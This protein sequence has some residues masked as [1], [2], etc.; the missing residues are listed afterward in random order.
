MWAWRMEVGMDGCSPG[1]GV[2]CECVCV[3]RVWYGVV[4][5]G[6]HNRIV[7]GFFSHIIPST[8]PYQYYT[9]ILWTTHSNVFFGR[10]SQAFPLLCPCFVLP[11]NR[12]ISMHTQCTKKWPRWQTPNNCK[13]VWCVAVQI[14][15]EQHSQPLSSNHMFRGPMLCGYTY[16]Y[17]NNSLSSDI[18]LK[19]R[20]LFES[21]QTQYTIRD[22]DKAE[23]V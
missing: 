21:I 11:C 3:R 22:G 18:P 9:G 5:T 19:K 15:T 4:P 12:S 1:V 8:I 17:R 23:Y 16:E 7:R 14:T 20:I 2:L 6:T 13:N 10:P